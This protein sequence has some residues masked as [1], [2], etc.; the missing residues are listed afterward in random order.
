MRIPDGTNEDAND[1]ASEELSPTD[2]E[3]EASPARI[4]HKKGR[5]GRRK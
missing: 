4:N 1:V 5:S 3:D 2:T